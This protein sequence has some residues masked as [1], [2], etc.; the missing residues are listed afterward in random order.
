MSTDWTVHILETS[1]YMIFSIPLLIILSYSVSEF[2][3]SPIFS[4]LR[5]R[6]SAEM[7]GNI[8]RA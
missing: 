6:P 3:L 5:L 4:I 7:R 2:C 1:Q 8:I